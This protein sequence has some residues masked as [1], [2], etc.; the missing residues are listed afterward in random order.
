MKSFY[1]K[2]SIVSTVL[3]IGGI[4]YNIYLMYT[5]PDV[6]IKAN[7]IDMLDLYR[8]KPILA[9]VNIFLGAGTIL[10]LI[11]I[12]LLIIADKRSTT[13][14]IVYV[15]SFRKKSTENNGS[16]TETEEADETSDHKKTEILEIIND[17]KKSS[18]D[19]CNKVL[20]HL[21]S[22]LE[23]STAALYLSR[24]S[25]KK[26][27]IELFASY[28]YIVPESKSITYEF[29]EGLAGQ[30]AK[31]GK[32]LNL[33]SVPEGYIKI[34]SGLGEA[35]PTHLIIIPLV[36]DKEVLGVAEI[37]SFK[38]FS[39]TQEVFLQEAF[40]SLAEHIITLENKESEVHSEQV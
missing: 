9:K 19:C 22:S 18:L 21:C 25:G 31:T 40:N 5:L 33:K 8:I 7:L 13:E 34:F 39:K 30:V 32:M 4:L 10:G 15:E 3:F 24:K 29:G 1:Q 14:N 20:L 16:V 38:E 11:T 6:L 36:K 2:L 35:S 37:A 12:I 23:A 26:R 28:A 17:N 27:F